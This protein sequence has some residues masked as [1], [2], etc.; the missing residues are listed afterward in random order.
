MLQ[1]N[2][3]EAIAENDAADLAKINSLVDIL[4]RLL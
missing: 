4:E 1:N 2:S 3:Y